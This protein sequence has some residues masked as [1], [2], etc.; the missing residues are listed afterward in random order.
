M[1]RLQTEMIHD[2]AAGLDALPLAEAAGILARQQAAA[3]QSVASA[4]TGIC[5]AAR[6]M[7]STLRSGGSLYYVAAGSSGLMAA[8]DAMELGGTFGIPPGRIRIH[9]AGGIP[10]TA[11]MPGDTEDR[12]DGLE[13]AL[14]EISAKDCA[15][16]VSASGATPYTVAAADLARRRNATVIGIANN[17]GSALLELSHH[18]VCI[19]TPPEVL[20]GS[21]R[22]GA[23]T[24][25]KIALNM[26]STL[27]ALDLGHVYDGLM[28]NLRADN[29]K[30]RQRAAGI[31]GA[32]AGADPDV[33]ADALAQSGGDVKIAVLIAA[34]AKS[35]ESARTLLVETGGHL[36]A[37]LG[38]IPG[39]A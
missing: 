7:A 14:S 20:S 6:S 36:R 16:A 37:A 25:Q 17:P 18:P 11:D 4:L 24:A 32:I 15:I 27:M 13:A 31:V 38:L 34:G 28:V 3:A 26:L 5:D 2:E 10:T 22:M 23:G 1:S 19:P 35:G 12:T 9:M 29:A 33:A 30:L 39:R 21:T 8:A